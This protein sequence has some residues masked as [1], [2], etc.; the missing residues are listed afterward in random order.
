[1]IY[2]K[3]KDFA[4]IN[5]RQKVDKQI[6]KTLGSQDNL[7]IQSNEK[8]ETE[9]SDSSD[10]GEEKEQS[11]EL[12]IDFEDNQEKKKTYLQTNKLKVSSKKE[13][14]REI[15]EFNGGLTGKNITRIMLDIP[16][17]IAGH[18]G[19]QKLSSFNRGEIHQIFTLYKTLHQVTSQRYKHGEYDIN[20]GV[21]FHVYQ[22]GLYQI[23]MQSQELQK[24]IF[25][26]CLLY[27][28]DAADD[29]QCVDLGGRRIIKK[30]KKTKQ[31]KHHQSILDTQHPTR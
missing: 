8:L 18:K 25:N 31:N 12:Q 13:T 26:T 7:Y 11:Q 9:Q 17:L 30:K 20:D 3:K 14:I 27:T 19:Q 1:M 24:R 23:Y 22:N 28:S 2:C 21:D 10:I 6:L 29:M 4:Q 16:K 5:S 15:D